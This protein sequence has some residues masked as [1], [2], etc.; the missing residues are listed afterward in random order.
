MPWPKGKPHT[1]EMKIKRAA[2]LAKNGKRRKK[3]NII[4]GSEYWK[5][6]T[7]REWRRSSEYYSDKRTPNGLKSSCKEC[8]LACSL[9]TRNSDLARESNRLHMARARQKDPEKFRE[10]DRLRKRPVDEKVRARSLLNGAVQCGRINKPQTCESCGVMGRITAHH[11][12]Y[13]KPLDVKW[14][15]YECH[16]ALHRKKV[17]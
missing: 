12:N 9:R 14:L 13:S 1:P 16:G 10:R 15:C 17:P 5:C 6:G 7:C 2:T 3:P 8:H 4:D 11:E